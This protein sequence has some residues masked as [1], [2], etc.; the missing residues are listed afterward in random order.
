MPKLPD[1]SRL[2]VLQKKLLYPLYHSLQD[3]NRSQ[4]VALDL[5]AVV[6][7]INDDA[8][9]PGRLLDLVQARRVIMWVGGPGAKERAVLGLLDLGAPLIVL[10]QG[11]E[12]H[13]PRPA[14]AL[15]GHQQVTHGERAH[16]FAHECDLII[17]PLRQA[18]VAR[19]RD[20]ADEPAISFLGG[21]CQKTRLL[22]VGILDAQDVRALRQQQTRGVEQNG[23][24]GRIAKPREK[25]GKVA[26]LVILTKKGVR[27]GLISKT[28]N[29]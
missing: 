12:P 3:L 23:H 25:D 11:C 15:V 13:A 29:V 22:L 27:D 17:R 10:Q 16:R 2:L 20:V 4:D 18:G 7:S 28:H 8:A 1:I 24:V 9:P 6:R 26:R 21:L 14:Q 5:Q 19:R